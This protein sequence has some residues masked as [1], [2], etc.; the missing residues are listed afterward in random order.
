M[1]WAEAFLLALASYAAAGLLFAL[2]FVTV[3]VQRLDPATAQAS[4][5][6]R[7]IILP[8]AVCFWP[9]LLLR[10]IRAKGAP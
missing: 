10:W 1:P 5:A 8:G 6:F 3:G 4:M 7:L 2:A 9:W